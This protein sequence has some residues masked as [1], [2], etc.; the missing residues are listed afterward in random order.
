MVTVFWHA[1]GVLLVD[2]LERG[3]TM[4]ARYHADLNFA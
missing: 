4:T 1:K 3:R 2:Y